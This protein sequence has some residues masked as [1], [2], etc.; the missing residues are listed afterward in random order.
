MHVPSLKIAFSD[1]ERAEILDRIDQI[2]A[3]GMLSQ[4]RY[5]REFEERFADYVGTRHALALNSGSSAIEIVMRMLHVA[6]K[7]VLVPT[8]T[9]LATAAGVLLAGGEVRL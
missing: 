2:L 3:T 5:V 6:G 4:G 1:G 9:F 8:N 7:E